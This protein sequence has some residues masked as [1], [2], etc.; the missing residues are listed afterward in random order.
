MTELRFDDLD[1]REEA[2]VP[3]RETRVAYSGAPPVNGAPV[4][5][6]TLTCCV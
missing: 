4:P 6:T 2:A 5:T 3:A 1:L